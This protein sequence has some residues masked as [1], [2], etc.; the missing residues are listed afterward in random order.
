[1]TAQNQLSERAQIGELIVFCIIIFLIFF[2]RIMMIFCEIL[3]VIFFSITGVLLLAGLLGLTW[4]VLRG[5]GSLKR[6]ETLLATLNLI[7]QAP[8]GGE[9]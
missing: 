5:I 8:S 2:E 4:R 6:R 3:L 7:T 1:M 9:A